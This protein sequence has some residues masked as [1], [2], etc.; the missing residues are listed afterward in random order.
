MSSTM[1]NTYAFVCT[2]TQMVM[3]FEGYIAT[4]AVCQKGNL[5]RTIRELS[6]DLSRSSSSQQQNHWVYD[7]AGSVQLP[8]SRT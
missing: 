5:G 8:G 4:E 6:S 1:A 7:T 2:V 3:I